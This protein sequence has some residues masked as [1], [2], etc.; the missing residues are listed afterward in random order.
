MDSI[1]ENGHSFKF[2][3][4]GEH[5]APS[6]ALLGRDNPYTLNVKLVDKDG[7]PVSGVKYKITST[8]D[9]A[10][11][12]VT[13]GMGR[14]YTS[15][16][17]GE[18]FYIEGLPAKT[19]ADLKNMQYAFSVDCETEGESETV[20]GRHPLR[21]GRLLRWGRPGISVKANPDKAVFSTKT[22]RVGK[23]ST[24]G[25]KWNWGEKVNQCK[26]KLGTSIEGSGATSP[27]NNNDGSFSA[28]PEIDLS[29]F[30]NVSKATLQFEG[31][32]SDDQ[33][34]AVLPSTENDVELYYF[35]S[36]AFTKPSVIVGV[37]AEVTCKLMG[38]DKKPRANVDVEWTTNFGTLD[39]AASK[40]DAQ[41]VAKTKCTANDAG[42][43]T[44]TVLSKAHRT[45]RGTSAA[46]GVGPLVIVDPV[47][48]ATQ[49]IEGRPP[50]KFSV[51]LQAA[52]QPV[53]DIMVEWLIDNVKES[54][55]Y[56]DEKGKADTS[57]VFQLGKH[58]VTAVVFGTVVAVD[59]EVI[60]MRAKKFDV[61]IEGGPFDL[62]SPDLLSRVADYTLIVKVLDD[63]N[64]P[65]DDIEFTLNALGE[66]P[67]SIGLSVEG[68]GV[69]KLSSFEGARF[70]IYAIPGVARD[71]A[72]TLAGPLTETVQLQYKL[73]FIYS[74]S[75]AVLSSTGELDLK[76]V[77]KVSA[78]D[79]YSGDPIENIGNVNFQVADAQ[80][81]LSIRLTRQPL[82]KG[83]PSADLSNVTN[84]SVS[85][86]SRLTALDG[87]LVMLAGEAPVVVY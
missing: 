70:G 64:R 78:V 58:T 56:S 4:I 87:Y 27:T 62:E 59:F 5:Y 86:V 75:S 77:R 80:A 45:I 82:F 28:A 1:N 50:I 30:S 7:K 40:T 26:L 84:G 36:V 55:S 23:E 29:K 9:G 20:I 67:S 16:E 2:A 42:T 32:L 11:L 18:D 15:S 34:T 47:A 22:E 73:G 25:A 74:Y 8:N 68:L 24:P 10:H 41:G 65:I 53:S 61:S 54:E 60:A 52:D 83:V 17:A 57:L 81:T 49:Y 71:F 69:K 12:V 3:I 37:P 38:L 72:L 35:Q 33:F 79:P 6:P 13:D 85:K 39:P 51:T 21:M 44:V 48:S 46:V 19:E 14:T 63:S 31:G 76:W 66:D 43:A